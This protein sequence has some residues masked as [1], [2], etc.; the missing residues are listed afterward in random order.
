M[1]NF[2]ESMIAVTPKQAI[3]TITAAVEADIPV[4]LWGSPGCGK[5]DVMRQVAKSLEMDLMDIRVSLL[6]PVDW[7]GLP[8]V[9]KDQQTVWARPNLLPP[10]TKKTKTLMYLDEINTGTQAVVA[11]SYQLLLDRCVGDHK[12]PEGTRLVA[13]GNLETDRAITVKMGSAWESRVLHLLLKVD[14]DD[15][16]EWAL[17]SDVA[18]E[19]IAFLRFRPDLIHQ[20]DPTTK[21]NAS[22]S[23][24][25]PR[26]WEFV[27]RLVKT[28]PS[29]RV[30][31]ALY[32]GVVGDAAALEFVSFLRVFRELPSVSEVLLN[33]DTAIIPESPA[34]NYAIS[35][36]VARHATKDNFD[37]VTVYAERMEPEYQVLLVRDAVRRDK[38]LMST[39][40]GIK[41]GAKHHGLLA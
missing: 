24:P 32:A 6:D 10:L 20:F 9:T 28:N 39:K 5:S 16:I 26:T 35:T 15:W 22:R 41:W 12:L 31:S 8:T 33:P 30:E 3:E 29:P 37:S 13:A 1:T 7:R 19:V 11:S 34:A 40:A 17:D 2:Y 18:P 25:C 21:N 4:M 14:L 27:S 38:G 36:A 23:F